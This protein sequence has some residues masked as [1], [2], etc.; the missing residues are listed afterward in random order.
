[1]SSCDS[2]YFNV[3]VGDNDILTIRRCGQRLWSLSS[4]TSTA[5]VWAQHI[6]L[7]WILSVWALTA[8]EWYDEVYC[9]T[10]LDSAK[11]KYESL[12]EKY[13]AQVRTKIQ[14]TTAECNEDYLDS[15]TDKVSLRKRFSF[16][17]KDFR[18]RPVRLD[19]GLVSNTR[20]GWSW[21][22]GRSEVNKLIFS[23]LVLRSMFLQCKSCIRFY[24]NCFNIFDYWNCSLPSLGPISCKNSQKAR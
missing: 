17:R 3:D 11:S 8:L 4:P 2:T 12:P 1:M 10:L 21:R 22:S 7:Y 23:I 20:S 16:R 19:Q 24:T 13:K 5:K 6:V 9:G 18:K 14:V 15:F